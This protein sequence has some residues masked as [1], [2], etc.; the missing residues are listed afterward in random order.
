MDCTVRLIVLS[1]QKSSFR[2]LKVT[3]CKMSDEIAADE[4]IGE[5][6]RAFLATRDPSKVSLKEIRAHLEEKFCRNLD[7]KRGLIRSTV[8]SIL[9]EVDAEEEHQDADFNVDQGNGVADD[10]EDEHQS[11]GKKKKKGGGGFTKPLLLS[12]ELANFM[13]TRTAS[14]TE[15]TKQI[16]AYIKEND[17]QNPK[18]KREVLLDERLQKLM[19]RKK[20]TMF[21]MTKILT[22]VIALYPSLMLLV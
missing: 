19:K 7:S 22:P 15:V 5:S 3:I 21:S 20:V 8:E 13:G 6:I 12:E 10:S 9:L 11:N 17:L 4:A 1:L 18:N 16:W 14:R 2:A